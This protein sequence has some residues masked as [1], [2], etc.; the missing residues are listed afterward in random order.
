MYRLVRASSVLMVCAVVVGASLAAGGDG[1]CR[2]ELLSPAPGALLD[3]GRRDGFDTINWEFTWKPCPKAKVYQLRVWGPSADVPRID[4]KDLRTP[5]FVHRSG[6][7]IHEGNQLGWRWMV[8]ARVKG[9]WGPWS[10]QTFDVEPTGRDLSGERAG[11][12]NERGC[13]NAPHSPA[14]RGTV[15]NGRRDARDLMIWSFSWQ[16]CTGDE[17]YHLVVRRK[18]APNQLID[19]DDIEVP[20]FRYESRAHVIDTELSGWTWKLR[21]KRKGTWGAWSQPYLFQVEPL[22]SDPPDPDLE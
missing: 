4:R 5:R 14:M 17:S 16:G 18:G 21:A 11:G 13:F 22:D 3:N 8:R 12:P 9:K 19:E 2:V 1:G 20:W 10:E 15:D 7:Y 6:G